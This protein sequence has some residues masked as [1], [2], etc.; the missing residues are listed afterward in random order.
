MLGEPE[1][2]VAPP[3]GVLRE[4]QRPAKRVGSG[5]AFDDR[6]EVKN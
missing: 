4:V 1:P 2:R 3:L 6:R 5:A